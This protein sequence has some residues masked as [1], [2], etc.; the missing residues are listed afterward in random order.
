[1]LWGEERRRSSPKSTSYRGPFNL[2]ISSNLSF[3]I[4][5]LFFLH[6]QSNIRL[7]SLIMLKPG[8]AVILGAGEGLGFSVARAFAK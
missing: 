6:P 2:D 4:L 5:N 3:L 8:V 1:M 7:Q